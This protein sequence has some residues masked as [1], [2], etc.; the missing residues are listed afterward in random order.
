MSSR[1]A[2]ASFFEAK[3]VRATGHASRRGRFLEV[4]RLFQAVFDDQV[5]V[6]P[7]IEDLASNLGVQFAKPANLSVLLRHQL[8]AHRRD[9]DEEIILGEVEVRRE[10]FC[11]IAL[12]VPCDRKGGG[13]VLPGDAVEIEEEG[14]LS[15]AVVGE[16]GLLRCGSFG[17]Q[18]APASTTP[19]YCCSSG[20]S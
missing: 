16:L 11:R 3:D 7:L 17:D 13:F 6:V 12:L 14:E 5:E 8:L 20:K 2:F 18:V 4:I 1:E 15:L 9:L 19:A 10:E